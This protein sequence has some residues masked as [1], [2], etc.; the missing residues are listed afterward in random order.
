MK[1]STK[2]FIMII[3]K[4]L[5]PFSIVFLV[6]TITALMVGTELFS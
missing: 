3:S 4:K 6:F 5:G 2:T 1:D